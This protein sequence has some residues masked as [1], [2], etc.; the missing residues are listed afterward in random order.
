MRNRILSKDDDNVKEYFSPQKRKQDNT[1]Q[2]WQGYMSIALN[3]TEAG[4]RQFLSQM[5]R[6]GSFQQIEKKQ[7]PVITEQEQYLETP[8]HSIV[9]SLD[10]QF[11]P[12]I[13]KSKDITSYE[14]L[15]QIYELHNRKARNQSLIEQLIGKTNNEIIVFPKTIHRK[16]I[17]KRSQRCQ[18]VAQKDIEL[19]SIKGQLIQVKQVQVQPLPKETTPKPLK[20]LIPIIKLE[21]TTSPIKKAIAPQSQNKK[22]VLIDDTRYWDIGYLKFIQCPSVLE[23]NQIINFTNA[24]QVLPAQHQKYYKLYVGRGN[25]HMMVKS[26]FSMRAQWTVGGNL[27]EDDLNFIW[28]QKFVDFPQSEIK[29]IQRSISNETIEGW[30]DSND[31]TLI[32]QAWDRVEGKSKKKL[33]DYNL[34]S[35]PILNNL[36]NVKELLTI[37]HQNQSIRIH[38]HLKE[39]NQLGDKKFLF[40]NLSKH[41]QENEIDLWTLIPLT[42]HI[43]GPNDQ[44][45][46]LFKKKFEEVSVDSQFKN[47]W[48]IKP[49][50]DS[51]RGQ[52]IKVCNNINEIY[53]HISQQ[54]HTFILQKYIENPFLYQKRKF[55]IRG[56][57]LITIINGAKKVFWYKKGYLRT[58]SSLF[59]LDSLDNQ[60]IHLTNDA[61][62]NKMNGYGKF[63]K[64][65]KVS[66]EQFQNYLLEQNK[67]NNTNYSFEEL[68]KNMKQLTKIACASSINQI[69]NT[70]QVLGFELYGLD[71]MITNEFKPILIEFNT[72]PCIETGCPVLA[73]IISGLLDN[74]FRFI[75]DPLFPAKKTN[76]D[77]FNSKNDFE[78]LLQSQLL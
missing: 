57:C 10:P 5:R 47:I 3:S 37:N 30:I 78:L 58:S 71:F 77:D 62:Q 11:P 68:Y 25:N 45:F 46:Y 70:D 16:N 31:Q 6:N 63:E 54:N 12:F 48:I 66:Y 65:N 40:L 64:G 15:S 2:I 9:K 60:K 50:E 13:R 61:I 67:Q 1:V 23:I 18:S 72:N 28:T 27:E 22:K 17:Q 32:R 19:D 24:L 8:N 4:V 52:G 53:Q 39:G 14:F 20:R 26:I 38:N 36:C 55:D 7:K 44:S 34:E 35:Q 41:C 43:Q 33:A 59:S 49:G 56:Y 75:I 76:L 42:Y 29:S 51:N 74:L 69:N 73:K 21:R